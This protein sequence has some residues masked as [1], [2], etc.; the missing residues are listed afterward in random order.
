VDLLGWSLIIL[1]FV[2]GMAGA[3]YPLLPGVVAIFAAFL[4]YGWFFEFEP[5][6]TW[7]WIFQTFILIIIFVADYLVSALGIKK[8]GGSKAAFW[9]STIGIL[10]GPFIIPVGGLI[11]GP[12]VGAVIG[13]LLNR[14]PLKKAFHIGWI[15]LLSLL[16]SMVVKIILQAV[17]IG[18]F[19]YSIF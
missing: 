15:S 5:F 7:F 12:F 17:M 13:E 2:I 4:V 14:V 9:G 11:I 6:G 1:L 3:I 19:L 8:Y 10:I 16:S 18:V